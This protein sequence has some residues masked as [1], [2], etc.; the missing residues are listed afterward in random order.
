MFSPSVEEENPP[1]VFK[2]HVIP[3]H[4]GD[5]VGHTTA[6][7]S[8]ALNKLESYYN[9]SATNEQSEIINNL[10]TFV[11]NNFDKDLTYENL[12]SFIEDQNLLGSIQNLFNIEL[13]RMH[14]SSEPY[15][16]TIQRAV[17]FLHQLLTEDYPEF[18]FDNYNINNVRAMM[19]IRPEVLNQKLRNTLELRNNF[20]EHMNQYRGGRRRKK[21][22]NSKKSKKSK[23]FR[24]FKRSKRSRRR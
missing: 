2:S 1:S 23:R 7:F 3:T 12:K 16:V 4:F 6:W 18:T 14:R 5:V 15:E 13:R 21:S 11:H 9:D 24:K 17:W 19:N 8:S 20:N 22:R 10:Y